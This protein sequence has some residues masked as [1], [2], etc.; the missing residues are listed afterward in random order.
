MSEVLI[1][2]HLII[3]AVHEEYSIKW[4]GKILDTKPKIKNK[5]LKNHLSQQ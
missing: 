2:T 4:I 5:L 1:K 3:T